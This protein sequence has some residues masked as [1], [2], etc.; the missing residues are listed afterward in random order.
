MGDKTY[1]EADIRLKLEHLLDIR[2][3]GKDGQKEALDALTSWCDL[4]RQTGEA[5]VDTVCEVAEMYD[6]SDSQY[7]ML[8]TMLFTEMGLAQVG[9]EEIGDKELLRRAGKTGEESSD[10]GEDEP[11]EEKA[12]SSNNAKK[13]Y[14]KEMLKYKKMSKEEVA[15]A[16]GV[17]REGMAA[18]DILSE[19]EDVLSPDEKKELK[20]KVRKGKA[21]REEIINRHWRLPVWAA[22]RIDEGAIDIMD[23]IQTGNLAVIEAVD[24]FDPAL[25]QFSTFVVP[26]IRKY[27]HVYLRE[28]DG[29]TKKTRRFAEDFTTLSRAKARLERQLSRQPTTTEIAMES[30]LPERKVIFLLRQDEIEKAKSLDEPIHHSNAANQLTVGDLVV[31]ETGERALE[32]IISKSRKEIR[33]TLAALLRK[34]LTP[35]EEIIVRLRKGMENGVCYPCEEIAKELGYSKENV[36]QIEKKAYVKLQS[37]QTI[38]LYDELLTDS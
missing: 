21:A 36:R 12:P 31:D 34:Y 38:N 35:T 37:L 22:F 28:Q 9:N 6:L 2:G 13:N 1:T 15:A 3:S 30:G 11:P 10:A 16:I 26:R 17:Y 24:R 29:I 32:D 33:Q 4:W 19:Q 20:G 8:C 5:D 25:G 23:L 14:I 27:I 7:T 18:Q